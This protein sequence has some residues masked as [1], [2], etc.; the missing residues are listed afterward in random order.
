MDTPEQSKQKVT[1]ILN[2][3]NAEYE[4]LPPEEQLEVLAELDTFLGEVLAKKQAFLDS[5]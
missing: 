5:K 4:N 1:D 2:G 3:I